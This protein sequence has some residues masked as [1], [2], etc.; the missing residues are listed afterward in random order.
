MLPDRCVL[1]DDPYN[2]ASPKELFASTMRLIKKTALW[3]ALKRLALGFGLIAL[4]SAVLLVTDLGH[5][6]AASAAS[7][8]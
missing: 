8:R 2:G 6:T 5:R 7:A 3:A 4:F 1:R